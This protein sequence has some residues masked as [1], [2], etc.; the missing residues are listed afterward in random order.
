MVKKIIEVSLND[1]KQ[2]QEFLKNDLPYCISILNSGGTIVFPTETLYGIG[3]DIYNEETIENLIKLKG[4]PKN[5]PIAVAVSS[6]IHVQEIAELSKFSTNLIKSCIS[7]PL[8]ILL[9]AK[10]GL[11]HRLTSGLNLIGIRFPDNPITKAILDKFGPITA[12]SANIHGTIN[13]VT[14]EPVIEQFNDLVDIYINTGPCP[15]GKGSTVI[16]PSGDTIKIIRDGACSGV[17]IE[18]CLKNIRR[19]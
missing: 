6:L 14:I 2:I 1:S 5:M 7:K 4:R 17:E 10:A 13:P 8:T 16:D 11:N 12:T 15:F 19:S 9:P 3:V 18:E